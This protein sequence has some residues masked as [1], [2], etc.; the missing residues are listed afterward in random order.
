[1]VKSIIKGCAVMACSL[2][3]T[4]C[5]EPIELDLEDN[6]PELVVEGYMTQRDY[7]IPE[8]GFDCG[9]GF[10]LT[11]DQIKLTTDI[12]DAFLNIDSIEAQTDYFPYNKVQL[13]STANYFEEG[14]T[15]RVSN[16]IVRLMKNGALVETLVEA[17]NEAGTYP[18]THLPEVGASYHLEIDAM[19]AFYETTPEIYKA[20]PPLIVLPDLPNVT[21]RPNFI[22]D[23]CQYYVGINT[24]EAIGRG[25][26]YRWMFYLNNEFVSDPVFIATFD[27]S[28]V[29]GICLLQFDIYGNSL[30]LSDTLIVFQMS[31]SEGYSNYINSFRNQTAFVGGPF[32]TPPAPIRGNVK[33]V[34]TGKDAFGYFICGGISATAVIVPDTIPV[35]GCGLD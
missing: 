12:T 18:I 1:M 19:D 14:A 15:P 20:I 23:S 24:Y 6:V 31:T 7:L 9:S 13:T 33:N 21:Y 17:P 25:D 4:A 5:Q 27:D 29:D 8:E 22:G 30:E 28:D 3:M 34:S 32:D 16:A 2:W 26:H 10:A 11:K 35:G